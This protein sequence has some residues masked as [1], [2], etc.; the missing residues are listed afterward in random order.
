ML[1]YVPHARGSNCALVARVQAIASYLPEASSQVLPSMS[2]GMMIPFE[3]APLKYGSRLEAI[4]A[5]TIKRFVNIWGGV[6][7]AYV[8]IVHFRMLIYRPVMKTE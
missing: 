4:S 8:R 7:G 2:G 6:E 5:D 3:W 1:K